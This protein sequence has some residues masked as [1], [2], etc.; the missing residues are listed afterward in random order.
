[1][2]KIVFASM[3]LLFSLVSA[4][5]TWRP[6]YAQMDPQDREWFRSQRNPTTNVP[7]CNEADGAKAQEDII[8]GHYRARFTARKYP[9]STSDPLAFEEVDS[10]WMDVPDDTVI[11]QANRHG[12]PVVWWWWKDG[13]LSI[14][15]YAP[16]AG[17]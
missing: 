5:A 9:A 16:G 17:L 12:A 13:L 2:I 15:C 8:D 4:M 6:E 7:C 14:R 10:G 11:K 3:V 1:M